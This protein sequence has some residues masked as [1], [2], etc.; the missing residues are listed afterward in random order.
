MTP[1]SHATTPDFRLDRRSRR[2]RLAWAIVL[3]ATPAIA[4]ALHPIVIRDAVPICFVRTVTGLPCPLCGLT[5]AFACAARGRFHEAIEH[6]PFWYVVAIVVVV[7]D[8]LL[9]ADAAIGTDTF[10]RVARTLKPYW[11]LLALV[12]AAF[13]VIRA[14][15]ML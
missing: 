11:P 2:R 4:W 15:G 8:G 9:I 14:A 7:V 5:R 6:H 12:L 13:G 1:P 10:G 3:T